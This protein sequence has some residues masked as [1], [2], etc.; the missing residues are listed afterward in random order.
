MPRRKLHPKHALVVADPLQVLE[1]RA[2]AF[3]QRGFED[4]VALHVFYVVPVDCLR[5]LEQLATD[6]GVS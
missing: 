6:I 2:E 4:L 3:E 1:A 5:L